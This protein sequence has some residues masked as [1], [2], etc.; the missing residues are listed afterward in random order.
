MD[1]VVDPLLDVV[2]RLGLRELVLVVRE[3]EVD[4]AAVDVNS[5]AQDVGAH[6]AALD[7]PPGPTLAP[8]ARPSRLPGLGSL[9]Q[10]KV[11]LSLLLA[12]VRRE[13]ALTVHRELHVLQGLLVE[14]GVLVVR[15]GLKRRNVEVNAAVGFVRVPSVDNR[16]N[17]LDNLVG[18]LAHAGQRVRPGDAH[19]AHILHELRL[20]RVRQG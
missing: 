9:P 7:V 16:L 10:H 2:V 19:E 13:R 11:I 5:L 14:L 6:G 17:V 8:R 1:E 18:V 20:E 15:R 12:R 3:V 4:A